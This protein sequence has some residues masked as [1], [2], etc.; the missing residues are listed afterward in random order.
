MELAAIDRDFPLILL[1]AESSLTK[2]KYDDNFT[3]KL[4]SLRKQRRY[5]RKLNRSPQS[6]DMYLSSI[7]SGHEEAHRAYSKEQLRLKISEVCQNIQEQRTYQSREKY[8]E[9]KKSHTDKDVANACATIA[10]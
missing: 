10:A 1:N 5:W 2:R 6:S 7:W 9:K 3:P 8:L 4:Q